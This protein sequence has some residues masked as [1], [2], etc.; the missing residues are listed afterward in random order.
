M[1]AAVA[2]T[3][4]E[5]EREKERGGEGERAR[6]CVC[7]CMHARMYVCMCVCVCTEVCKCGGLKESLVCLGHLSSST[8]EEV[9]KGA[10]RRCGRLAAEERLRS[11]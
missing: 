7:V 5:R 3:M 8:L 6:M 11:D 2:K 10:G 4:T 9:S 1:R